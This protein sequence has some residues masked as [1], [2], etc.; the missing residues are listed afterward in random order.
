[1]LITFY[2]I[3]TFF[4]NNCDVLTQIK[5]HLKLV[6]NNMLPVGSQVGRKVNIHL[7][8]SEH[9]SLPSM[10]HSRPV[11]PQEINTDIDINGAS[12]TEDGNMCVTSNIQLLEP[13][14]EMTGLLEKNDRIFRQYCLC[15]CQCPCRLSRC[16]CL[17]GRV[18]LN[19]ALHWRLAPRRHGR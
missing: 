8:Q 18:L 4:L 6:Q 14:R 3:Y 1:M 7:L 15:R 19:L 17:R 13:V 10:Q 16:R 9:L 12:V 2:I 11:A 5:F